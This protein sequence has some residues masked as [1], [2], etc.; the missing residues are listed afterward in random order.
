MTALIEK[1][2]KKGD[3]H[4]ENGDSVEETKRYRV[5]DRFGRA[6][7]EL[8]ENKISPDITSRI[9]LVRPETWSATLKDLE[10]LPD[11]RSF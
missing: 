8:I 3:S 11:G 6:N 9:G 7:A 10:L 1:A 5:L 4:V 2:E